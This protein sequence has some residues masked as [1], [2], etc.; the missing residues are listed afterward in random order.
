MSFELLNF[1]YK[2][3]VIPL[4]GGLIGYATNYIAVKMIFRPKKGIKIGPFLFQG[5]IPK[6]KKELADS[7]AEVVEEN[8][9]STA[10]LKEKILN[11]ELGEDFTTLINEKVDIFLNTKLLSFNPI[12]AAFVTDDI[13]SKI[14]N[15]FMTELD[16]VLPSVF[17]LVGGKL[18]GVIDISGTVV[19]K[20]N[21]F[22]TDK[23]EE[24]ILSVASKELKTIEFLGGVLGVLIG[25]V[26][27][28]IFK[29]L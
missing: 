26:Q 1:D 29:F 3:I 27:V 23:L 15:I 2:M 24:I 8:L 12:L 5:I 17:D 7:I 25:I 16:D 14:K 6:R 9:V 28:V 11:M 21:E 4:I 18:D 22:S 20:V 13:K 19:K 10:E